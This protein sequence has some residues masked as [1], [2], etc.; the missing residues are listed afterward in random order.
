MAFKD[1]IQ[2]PLGT[3][4]TGGLVGLAGSA[5]QHQYN[6][7]LA[8]YQN[9]LNVSNWNMQNEYNTPVNQRKRLEEAGINPAVAF[10]NNSAGN[11]G[12]IASYQ[13]PSVDITSN[14]LQGAQLAQMLANVRKTNAE[15]ENVELTNPFAAKTAEAILDNYI[16]TKE[17][18][19]VDTDK[20]LQEIENLKVGYSKVQKEIG[21]IEGQINLQKQQVKT[22]EE[23]TRL[24]R[25]QADLEILNQALVQVQTDNAKKTG[26]LLYNQNLLT[27]AQTKEVNAEAVM[28]E[29]KNIYYERYGIFPDSNSWQLGLQTMLG[30]GDNAAEKAGKV[31]GNRKQRKQ[32]KKDLKTL[33]EGGIPVAPR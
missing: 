21:Y 4:L 7:S 30:T 26:D 8:K 17:K 3:S 32:V 19:K 28:K 18:T 23:K 10:G 12:S 13:A 33:Q 9:D 22:E 20:S 11:A 1:F 16:A 31:I 15:A 2:S 14:M 29:F 6:K 5:L 25:A 24:V 27:Q